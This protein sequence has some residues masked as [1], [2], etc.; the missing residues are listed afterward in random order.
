[1]GIKKKVHRVIY[2]SKPKK[3]ACLALI[4]EHFNKYPDD[5]IATISIIK[6]KPKRSE[7]QS[8]LYFSWRDVIGKFLG[9]TPTEMHH[10]LKKSFIDGGSTKELTVEQFVVYLLEI[11]VLADD[12]GIKLPRDSDHS[13]AIHGK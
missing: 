10:I 9:N 12:L 5:E 1:M 11:E 13:L 2:K 6:G 8:N 4:T 7:A 3:E